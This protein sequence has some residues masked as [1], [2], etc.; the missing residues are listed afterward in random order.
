MEARQYFSPS[1]IDGASADGVIASRRASV[2]DPHADAAG[3]R[4]DVPATTSRDRSEALVDEVS[5]AIRETAMALE[6][7]RAVQGRL[8]ARALRSAAVELRITSRALVD[9][10]KTLRT[11][12]QS[13]LAQDREIRVAADKMAGTATREFLREALATHNLDGYGEVT[14]L[15]ATELVTNV[16][17]HVGCDIVVRLH[18]SPGAIRVEVDDTSTGAP[19]VREKDP[20]TERGNGMLLVD[21]LATRWGVDE[22]PTSKTVWFELD[23]VTATEEVHGPD[24][25]S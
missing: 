15:L 19:A 11:A 10:A 14:E 24:A 22:H 23:T 18:A 6:S 4:S 2:A 1:K 12:Q 20:T 8:A 16:V 21:G 13:P 17:D 7:V 3:R 5:L 9:E 25:A